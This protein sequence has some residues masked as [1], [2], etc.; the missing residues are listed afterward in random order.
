MSTEPGAPNRKWYAIR[1][2]SNFE[3]STAQALHGKAIEALL[4]LCRQR[5]NRHGNLRTIERPL[6]PGYVFGRFDVRDRVSVLTIP[7]VVHI[8]SAGRTPVPLD[9]G[10]AAALKRIGESRLP[11]E[12]WPFLKVGQRVWIERGPLRGLE[13]IILKF[14]GAYWLIASVTL[15]ERSVAVLIDRESVRPD[16]QGI[17]SAGLTLAV[18]A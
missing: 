15:L 10:E 5:S 3:K 7:G 4:P 8:V 12:P 18:G 16:A 13:G 9:D 17:Y 11:V 2:A 14:K 6:F 1:V